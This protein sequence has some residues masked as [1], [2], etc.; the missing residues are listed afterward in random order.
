MIVVCKTDRLLWVFMSP[1]RPGMMTEMYYRN[2]INTNMK[3]AERWYS[4]VCWDSAHPDRLI[5]C[6][7]KIQPWAF[8]DR[9]CL[10]SVQMYGFIVQDDMLGGYD[11]LIL[12]LLTEKPIFIVQY[13][14]RVRCCKDCTSGGWEAIVSCQDR[15]CRIIFERATLVNSLSKFRERAVS[16]VIL[17]CIHVCRS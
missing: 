3:R 15:F 1:L 16:V 7:P 4:I 11:T 5:Y 8:N 12:C 6:R 9:R 2:L 14:G 13:W 10:P 17:R